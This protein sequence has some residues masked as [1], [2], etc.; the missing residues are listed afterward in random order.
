MEQAQRTQ[1]VAALNRMREIVAEVFLMIMGGAE[2]LRSQ[3]Q[4]RQRHDDASSHQ[5]EIVL[6]PLR[7]WH[8]KAIPRGL[9][10]EVAPSAAF[11]T[12]LVA[13]PRW[14]MNY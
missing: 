3:Q 14:V 13:W 5:A 11:L 12:A 8:V 4:Q 2:R 10:K 6:A 1:R 7:H 9:Q